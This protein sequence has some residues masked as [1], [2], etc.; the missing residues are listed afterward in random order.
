MKSPNQ[1]PTL[2]RDSNSPL[3][4]KQKSL[5]S[6][7]KLRESSLSNNERKKSNVDLI[8]QLENDTPSQKVIGSTQKLNLKQI[9]EISSEK[10]DTDKPLKFVAKTIA[11]KFND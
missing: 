2:R 4:I 1:H 6:Q 11:E 9:R 7:K 5:S 10:A 3:K 8:K